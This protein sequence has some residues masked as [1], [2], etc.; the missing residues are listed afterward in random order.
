MDTQP[1]QPFRFLNLPAELRLMVYER[2]YGIIYQIILFD[3]GIDA[4]WPAYTIPS[5]L[6]Y[7]NR[8]IYSELQ[9]LHP[10]ESNE[11]ATDLV[12]FWPQPPMLWVLFKIL[13]RIIALCRLK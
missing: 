2:H 5:G 11:E 1:A 7:V 4:Y 9:A 6:P 8:Q 13:E 12:C 10:T 3:D